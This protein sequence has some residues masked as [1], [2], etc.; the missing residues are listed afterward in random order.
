MARRIGT[1]GLVNYKSHPTNKQY[2]IFSFYSLAEAEQFKAELEERKIWFEYDQEQF[3]PRP[4]LGQDQKTETVYLFGV[5]KNDF[6]RVQKVN[7]IVS[8][9][10]R[11]HMIKNGFLR[12]ALI[13]FFFGML[14]LGI[15]GYV[16]NMNKLQEKTEQLENE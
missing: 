11:S 8:G 16:K 14:T 10:H 1:L 3:E 2:K 5:H 7:F 15:V 12:Y 4:M 6:G 9:K 13:I